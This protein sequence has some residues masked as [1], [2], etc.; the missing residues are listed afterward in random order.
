MKKTTSLHDKQ[1]RTKAVNNDLR[2]EYVPYKKYRVQIPHDH[3][4]D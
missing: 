2:A 4:L 3:R 1:S